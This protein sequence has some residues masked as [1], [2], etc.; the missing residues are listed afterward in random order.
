MESLKSNSMA[1]KAFLI[2]FVGMDG[3]GKT[4]Q[5]KRLVNALEARGVKCKYVWNTYQPFITKPFLLLGKAAFFRGKD[6]FKD[7]AEYSSTKIK[8]FRTPILSRVYEYLSLFD[9]LCQ[10][11]VTVRLPRMFGSNIICDRYVPD[12]AVNLAAELGYS[13][14]KLSST[15]N[16]LSGLLPKPDLAFLLDVPAE[17]GY[18]R[19]DDTPSVEHLRS[20]RGIYLTIGQEYGV[21][22]DGTEDPAELESVILDKVNRATGWSENS[23]IELLR[24]IGSPL[25][26]EKER[27]SA[28]AYESRGLYQ[29]AAKNKISLLYLNALDRHGKLNELKPEYKEQQARY[30]IFLEAIARVASI[31]DAARIEYVVFKTIKPHPALP[32]DVDVMVLNSHYKESIRALLK[33]GYTPLLSEV[34][35]TAALT[36]EGDYEKAT[37]ILCKSTYGKTH[38]SPTGSTFIDGECNV[39][40]DLQKDLAVSYVIYM[41]KSKFTQHLIS[42]GLPNGIKVKTLAPE[43]DLATVIAHSLME[44]TY[45]LGEF[46][47]FSHYLSDMDEKKVSNFINIVKENRLKSALR[48]LAT[49]TAEL[50]KAAYG[51][52]PESLKSILTEV[53]LDA[54]EAKNLER[55]NFRMP[56]KYKALTVI[57]FLLEKSGEPGFR[58]SVLTQV[59]KML[60]PNL[61]KL[62]I[63][64][65][66]GMRRRENYLKEAG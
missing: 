34:I 37:E 55:N 3:T 42:T 12:V 65:L 26:R 58:K 41:D 49:I 31:L 7:Y 66:I 20:L 11:L 15:L 48:T 5:A 28:D 51:K 52:V 30:P 56:H 23:T 46:Y 9:Y 50:H 45:S 18:Q 2:C 35:N 14:K 63:R 61:T 17:I 53:G 32:S 40:I 1:K 44:Q 33:V 24:V 36:S 60:N 16:K 13:D 64:E 8:V 47:T 39:H 27:F 29:F 54:S 57:K 43:L 38:I 59:I 19:K 25:A 4:T 6:A 62:V 21:V 10:S 22:L